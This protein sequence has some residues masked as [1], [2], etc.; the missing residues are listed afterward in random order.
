MDLEELW[1]GAVKWSNLA[2][3]TDKLR[4]FVNTAMNH[5]HAKNFWIGW[6]TVSFSIAVLFHRATWWRKWHSE[7]I[8]D[9]VCSSFRWKGCIS[10]GADLGSIPGRAL[11]HFVHPISVTQ[12][13]FHSWVCPWGKST[14][15]C[16]WRFTASKPSGQLHHYCCPVVVGWCLVSPETN[17]A[18]CTI[19]KKF[20]GTGVRWAVHVA[21]LWEI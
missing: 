9:L 21:H 16:R 5:K 18:R 11:H 10:L 4:T 12:P 19:V 3:N 7:G 8:H 6:E 17:L 15:E 14:G 1:L 2:R 20:K 13:T